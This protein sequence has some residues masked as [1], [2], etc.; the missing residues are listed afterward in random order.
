MNSIKTHTLP[1]PEPVSKAHSDRLLE[2]IKQRILASGPMPF[3]QYMQMALYEP[4]LGYYS[5]GAQKLGATGDFVT[6]PEI[7]PLFSYCLARQCQQVLEIVGGGDI[8]EL[9][10]GSG[11]MAA[12]MLLELERLQSLPNHYYIVEVS[13]DLR[14]RQ[15]HYLSQHCSHLMDKISWLDALPQQG[16]RGVIVGNEVVDAMPVHK[17]QMNNGIKE[18][19]VG[20]NDGELVWC[21]A[22]PSTAELEHYVAGMELAEGYESEVNGLLKPWVA[23]LAD[24]LQQGLILLIDYGFPRHEYYHHDRSMGTLMCHY[25]H[26]AHSDPLIYPGIQDITAHVD[27][28]AIAE[29]GSEQG[30]AVKGFTHQAAFLINLGLGEY[31]Q[32]EYMQNESM[33]SESMNYIKKAQ[34]IKILTM[35]SEMGEL[36][37]AIALARNVDEPLNGFMQMNQL[38]RL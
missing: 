14:E 18:F 6:A 34:Q 30:L 27:F 17:F 28:T 9:G 29:V 23:S 31:M 36:F 12:D 26:R 35:P 10:A 5:A 24:C 19:Y 11:V 13:A 8:L 37:K 16:F 15:Q 2:I 21:I 3:V 38:E 4:G 7:S 32:G 33:Q 25:R 20:L 1:A 22:E